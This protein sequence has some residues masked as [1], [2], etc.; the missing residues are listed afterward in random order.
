[1]DGS[2]LIEQTLFAGSSAVKWSCLSVNKSRWK[3]NGVPV[4]TCLVHDTGMVKC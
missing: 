3:Q 2:K 4:S 1:M